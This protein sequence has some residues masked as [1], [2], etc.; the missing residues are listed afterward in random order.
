MRAF[1]GLGSNQNDPQTQLDHALTAL[2]ELPDTQLLRCSP[3][4]WTPP[5]GDVDQAEF[6]NA[7]AELSTRLQPQALLLAMQEIENAQDRQRD[8]HRR[9]GP[10]PL[11]LDLLLYGEQIIERPE[12]RVPHPHM[13]ERAFVL[14]PLTNLAPDIDIPGQGRASLLLAEHDTRQLRPA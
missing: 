12:L 14:L 3:R 1:I 8:S 9:W 4:Y 13:H 10:R 5:W 11:D 2:D 7:V 6:L